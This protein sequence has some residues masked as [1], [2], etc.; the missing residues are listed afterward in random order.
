[1]SNRL[2]KSV[3]VAANVAIVLVAV[4]LG[5]ALF[6]NYLLGGTA[7]A[8]A[9]PSG[10]AAGTKLSVEG[11]DWARNRRT[12]LLVL[13]DHCHFCTESA[14]FYKRLAADGA[15]HD[16]TRLVALLP[17]SVA[18]GR[19]Y[20]E[21]LGVAVDDVKQAQPGAVGVEGTPTLILVN[22]AGEVTESWVGKLT[23]EGEEAVLTR[24]RA[25]D[26]R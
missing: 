14:D 18:A 23:H 24:L 26:S 1:M 13:S 16:G 12:L 20:L 10:I 8:V 3:E 17:Q 4:L 25:R 5:V 6:K 11:M 2:T 15:A 7:R 9:P 21:G 19:A 22:D